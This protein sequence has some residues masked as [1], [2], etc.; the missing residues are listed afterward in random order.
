[1]AESFLIN[2]KNGKG[3]AINLKV[4]GTLKKAFCD[5]SSL[6]L[7]T[8]KIPYKNAGDILSEYNSAD[9]TGK[10]YDIVHAKS[11][12][13]YIPFFDISSDKTKYYFEK[14][15]HF[16]EEREYKKIH[17]EKLELDHDSTLREYIQ[18][19]I[20]E[21]ITMTNNSLITEYG[22]IVSFKLKETILAKY[23][24][25]PNMGVKNYI[26]SRSGLLTSLLSSY[27]ELRNLTYEYIN[28]L[29]GLKLSTRRTLE[30]VK[31]WDNS[32]LYEDNPIP[33]K[34]NEQLDLFDVYDFPRERKKG[35]NN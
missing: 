28:L 30:T 14:L 17:G 21:I 19:I 24:D 8:M 18:R 16:A 5:I 26:D 33:K 29:E 22:S 10:Y 27:T 25:Y 23:T 20:Y 6:D 9:L 31:K 1:M 35:T 11:D 7:Q 2:G 13:F 12:K 32:G 15:R 4:D 34:E 3:N